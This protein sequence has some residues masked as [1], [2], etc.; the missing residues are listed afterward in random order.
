ME[1]RGSTALLTG[2][3]GG[4][5]RA[6]AAEMAGCGA[7]LMLSARDQ[8]ALERLAASLPGDGHRAIAADLEA[9]GAAEKLLLDAGPVGIL[10]ANAGVSGHGAVEGP[11]FDAIARI[12]KIN[13]EVPLMLSAGA[14]E[15][16]RER[17]Q[18]HVVLIASL[19]GKIIPANSALYAATKAALRAFGLG[20]RDDYF[21]TAISA[22]VVSPGYVRDAGMFASW[23]GKAPFGLGTASPADVGAAVAR[24]VSKDI[25]EIDVAPRRQRLLA[26]LAFH[27]H[28]PG[29]RLGR[30]IR[31]LKRA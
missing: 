13:V 3:T 29:A 23:G 8:Q 25:A 18:G 7:K 12:L 4:L 6:I 24:A 30:T 20:V 10:I 1:I 28:G 21:G 9:Q 19:S 31:A 11:D 27:F 22:S 17:Q 26:N 15:S 16:M 5:G 14:L 2:A